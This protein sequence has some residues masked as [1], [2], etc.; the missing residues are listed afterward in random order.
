MMLYRRSVAG[1]K[2]V[3]SIELDLGSFRL[4]S[5]AAAANK[6]IAPGSAMMTTL[7]IAQN[8]GVCIGTGQN[9]NPCSSEDSGIKYRDLAY[10]GGMEHTNTHLP[11]R[12]GLGTNHNHYV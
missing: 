2:D 4:D 1:V 8:G 11:T 12:Q 9:V 3:A 5:Q 10:V 6:S 7:G